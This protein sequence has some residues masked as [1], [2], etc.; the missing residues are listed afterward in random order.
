MVTGIPFCTANDAVERDPV[1]WELS[2][3][4]NGIDGPYTLIAKGPITDFVGA[5]W[6]R[7]TWNTTPI[8]F[9]NTVSYTSYQLMLPPVQQS[10]RRQQHADRRDRAVGGRPGATGPKP[11]ERRQGVTMPLLQWT[12]GDMAQFEDVYVGT[13]PDLTDGRPQ[14]L[15][16]AGRTER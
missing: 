11:A 5:T 8:A 2:G 13:S 7:R 12:P 9:A 10:G 4:N 1:A 6:A 14:V 16:S 3:S 15:P